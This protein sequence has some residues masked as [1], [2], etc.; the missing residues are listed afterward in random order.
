MLTG[1]QLC[2]CGV[3]LGPPVAQA[4][5]GPAWPHSSFLHKLLLQIIIIIV[6]IIHIDHNFADTFLTF[7][8]LFT[9]YPTPS[10]PY[11]WTD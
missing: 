3:W 6:I 4:S 8:F 9:Q 2:H 5:D 1:P 10:N 7:F 11:P